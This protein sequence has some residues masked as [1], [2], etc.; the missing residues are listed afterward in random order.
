[1]KVTPDFP[2]Y[3]REDPRRAA[4]LRVYNELANSQAPGQAVYELKATP[5]APEVD[6]GIWL[7][8]VAR[9]GLQVKGGQYTNLNGVWRLHTGI[10]AEIVTC[11][12]KQTW[13]AAISI[14]DAVKD[15]LHRK[16]FILPVLLFPDM[17]PDSAIEEWT[18]NDRVRVLWGSE[19][20]VNRLIQL[21]QSQRVDYPP[22]ALHIQ[23]ELAVVAPGLETPAQKGAAP[24]KTMEPVVP[25]LIIQH[26][27]INLYLTPEA[28]EKVLLKLPFAE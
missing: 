13:D 21:A 27:D 16:I 12:L 10:D 11:P 15:R 7:E 18:A 4:E 20:L 14:R 26:V 2:D 5:E 1:M 3:R 9:V 24:A 17:E 19:D 6:F 25:Q 22:T 28:L 23:R 8:D